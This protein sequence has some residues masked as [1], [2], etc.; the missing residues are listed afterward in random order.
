MRKIN[1]ALLQIGKL[2]L[3]KLNSSVNKRGFLQTYAKQMCKRLPAPNPGR[4]A[5]WGKVI[6]G[7]FAWESGAFILLWILLNQR[8]AYFYSSN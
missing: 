5:Q 7:F 1:N 6:G 4:A 8:K 2:G 3:T